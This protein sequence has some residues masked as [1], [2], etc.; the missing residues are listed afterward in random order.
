MKVYVSD[1]HVC[2]LVRLG[3]MVTS[4]VKP[5]RQI[6]SEGNTMEQIYSCVIKHLQLIFERIQNVPRLGSVCGS[7]VD[8]PMKIIISKVI[9]NTKH[10]CVPRAHINEPKPIR[11]QIYPHP[12]FYDEPPAH[13]TTSI[14]WNNFPVNQFQQAT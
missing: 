11:K 1:I 2:L 9:L 14:R 3:L 7:T 10:A 4:G 12:A 6:C 13:S 8:T 5:N